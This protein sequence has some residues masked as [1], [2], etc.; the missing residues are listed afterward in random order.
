MGMK[1]LTPSDDYTV[2]F[3]CNG[4]YKGVKYHYV[5]MYLD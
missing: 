3:D 1:L 2:V 4:L 5:A